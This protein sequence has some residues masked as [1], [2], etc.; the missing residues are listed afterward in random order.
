MSDRRN[1]VVNCD[2]AHCNEDEL[3]KI[4]YSMAEDKDV[5]FLENFKIIGLPMRQETVSRIKQALVR[6]RVLYQQSSTYTTT[7][8]H[9]AAATIQ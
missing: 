1:M 4:L 8:H 2:I 9:S 7:E 3:C 5:S 6:I